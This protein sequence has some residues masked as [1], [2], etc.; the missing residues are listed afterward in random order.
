MGKFSVVQFALYQALFIAMLGL[1]CGLIYP[2]VGS[3]IDV[4]ILPSWPSTESIRGIGSFLVFLLKWLWA[5]IWIPW[6][7][8]IIGLVAGI[9]EGIVIKPFLGLFGGSS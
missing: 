5:L 1:V 3:F 7:F 8:G 9:V 6:V 2:F 4:S